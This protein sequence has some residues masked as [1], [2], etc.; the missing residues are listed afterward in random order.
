MEKLRNTWWNRLFHSKEIKANS[1][2]K[3]KLKNITASAPSFIIRIGDVTYKKGNRDS[4]CITGVKSLTELLAIH[5]ELW[6]TGFQNKNL[7][8][9]P[10]GMFRTESI[11]T[12]KAEE[13]FLGDIYGLWTKDIPFWE[14]HKDEGKSFGGWPIYEYLTVYQ[15]VLE[16]YKRLLHSNV[17]TIAEDAENDLKELEKLGY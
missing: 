6:N 3:Q 16:Q 5:K 17:H 10:Y 2:H 14:Q 4:A 12:M 8:P 9:N 1:E 15:I 11:P 7:R 13:V